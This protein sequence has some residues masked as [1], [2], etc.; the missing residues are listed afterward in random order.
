[1]GRLAAA[2]PYFDPGELTWEVYWCDLH[3]IPSEKLIHAFAECRMTLKFF[4][5][6][7]EIVEKAIGSDYGVAEYNPTRPAT[8]RDIIVGYMRKKENWEETRRL[9]ENAKG[10]IGTRH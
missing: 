9:A 6:V 8:L 1:M 3:F 2:Y 5:S 7:S 4:P 10:Q